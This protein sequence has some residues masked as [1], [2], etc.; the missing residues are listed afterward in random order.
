M[1]II[2]YK[3]DDNIHENRYI[4]NPR[5]MSNAE[6]SFICVTVCE[7]AVL[8]FYFASAFFKIFSPFTIK[9]K[10]IIQT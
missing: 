1:L 2:V 10:N 4:V 3:H 5:C 7:E 8:I 6:L 9:Q